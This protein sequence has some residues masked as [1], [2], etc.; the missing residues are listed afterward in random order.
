[1]R[2]LV[3]WAL[4]TGSNGCL[5]YEVDV[6]PAR[7]TTFVDGQQGEPTPEQITRL[8]PVE[9][10]VFQP[11]YEPVI[12][13]PGVS[14]LRLAPV[15]MPSRKTML[16]RD[17]VEALRLLRAAVVAARA[18][19]C[20]AVRD[21]GDQVRTLDEALHRRIFSRELAIQPC[22]VTEPATGP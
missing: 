15:T 16:L 6:A 20:P 7:A 19:D 1:M 8:V 12:V 9:V 22:L 3:A 21:L 13:A 10:M 2:W 18:N 14:K 4:L 5:K 17:R 11:G